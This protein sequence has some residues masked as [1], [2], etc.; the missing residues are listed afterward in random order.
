MLLFLLLITYDSLPPLPDL[1]R[2]TFPQPPLRTLQP[3][4]TLQTTGGAGEF[5]FASGK[6]QYENLVAGGDYSDRFVWGDARYGKGTVSYALGFPSFWIQPVLKGFSMKGNDEYLCFIP[7]FDFA[8]TNPWSVMCGTFGYAIWDINTTRTI[9]ASTRFD[10]IFDRTTN[11]P[12]V[13]LEGIYTNDHYYQLCG[14]SIHIQHFHITATS[15]VND[16]FPSPC[17]SIASLHPSY[18]VISEIRTGAV[19]K[20]L[21]DRFDPHVPLH[22]TMAAPVES[23]RVAA[24]LDIAFDLYNHTFEM[25]GNYRSWHNRLLPARNFTQGETLDLQEGD[26]NLRI[27]NAID[28]ANLHITNAVCGSYSWHDNALPFRPRY[29]VVDTLDLEYHFI[30]TEVTLEYRT[31]HTGIAA[32]LPACL[33]I[34]PRAGL[35]YRSLTL[36]AAVMNSTGTDREYYDGYHIPARAF[37]G[38]VRFR[39]TF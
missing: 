1:S 8:T 37:A 18:R 26:V 23:L 30:F 5:I 12:L 33:I 20:T 9:E 39:K 24:R 25:T 35:R 34:N 32:D 6:L 28:H 31:A 10:I 22:Y 19:L 17:I 13:M 36:F 38:G 16:F 29:S 27:R 15:P 11:K 3:D 7:G 2:I 14:G 4:N 21:G